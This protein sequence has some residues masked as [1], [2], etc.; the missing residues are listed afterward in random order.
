[1]V[2]ETAGSSHASVKT[3]FFMTEQT[4]QTTSATAA[5]IAGAAIPTTASTT[6]SVSGLYRYFGTRAA[7]RDINF[8][9]R[10]GEILGLLGPNGAG[11]TT[12]LRMLTDNLAPSAGTI[13]I[14]GIDIQR[15]P[16]E[17]KAHIGYL[18]EIPPLY[19]E[20]TVNEYLR[21]AARLHGIEKQKINAAMDEVMQ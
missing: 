13:K 7:V 4:A 20:L 12:I 19:R 9:L 16:R 10:R 11:K 2:T 3:G 14:C 1:M 5:T 17:A 21:L 15:E 8:E 18:P 6:V